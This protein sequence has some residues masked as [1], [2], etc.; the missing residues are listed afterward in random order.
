MSLS[1]RSVL[2]T[3]LGAAAAVLTGCSTGSAA[4]PAPSSAAGF[5]AT[6]PGK[7]GAVTVLKP[8]T[9]VVAAGYLRDTDIA[10]ALRAP[11]VGVARNS[12]FPSGLAPWQQTDAE[13]FDTSGGM[14][15]ER[16]AALRPDLILASD[17]Y[18]LAKDHPNLAKLAPTLGYQA[19]VGTDSWQAM[20]TRAGQVLGKQ[21]EARDLVART[22]QT[23][24]NARDSNKILA[25]KTFTF[26]P[27]STLD[28]M[29]TINGS[30]DASAKFF[31]Q[32]GLVLSP[33]VTSLP[34]SST[35]G[36]AQISME[37]LGLLDADV[38]IIAFTAPGIRAEFEAQPLF[39][40][41]KAV[42]RGSYIALDTA[43]AVAVAF[44]SVL[45]IPYGLS[46]TVPKLV[47]AAGKV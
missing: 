26:G 22:E 1:R 18:T 14:P 34:A 15:F 33:Q 29:F 9:R 6:V 19:G 20:T 46:A 37:Q 40:S 12:V 42:R 38:M 47:A 43:S 27:V 5:P 23:V 2:A 16:I 8:P 36:R 41:L 11:L 32:L 28:S 10:L 7:E 13:L 39:Q 31:G 44:P 21:A 24:T 25:G 30:A 17:D 45:S 3:G 35:P 4:A